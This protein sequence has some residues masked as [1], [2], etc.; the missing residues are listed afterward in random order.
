MYTAAMNGLGR[1]SDFISLL[2]LHFSLSWLFE[3]SDTTYILLPARAG[4]ESAPYDGRRIDRDSIQY[5]PY[6][7]QLFS[8]I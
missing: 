6:V 1:F 2:T 4:V 5:E 3:D 8:S 7:E